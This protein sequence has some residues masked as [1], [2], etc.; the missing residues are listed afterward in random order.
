MAERMTYC[1]T[2]QTV[3]VAE[4]PTAAAQRALDGLGKD[5]E[6]FLVE[7]VQTQKQTLVTLVKDE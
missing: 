5:D 7:N 6:Q 1:I 2:W 4:S 3:V